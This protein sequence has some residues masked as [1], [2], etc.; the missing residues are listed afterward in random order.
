MQ[1]TRCFLRIAAA[2]WVSCGLL[3]VDLA[4]KVW[5]LACGTPT[6]TGVACTLQPLLLFT[7][8]G[9]SFWKHC[10]L[11]QGGAPEVWSLA[12]GTPTHTH[13]HIFFGSTVLFSR[14]GHQRCVMFQAPRHTRTSK[15]IFFGGAFF[16]PRVGLRNGGTA[17]EATGA[18][19]A[20][21]CQV[22]T[23]AC[24]TPHKHRCQF[25]SLEGCW[26]CD[27]TEHW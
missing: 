5:S 27:Q 7:H 26:L 11:F 13:R 2:G 19:P 3:T 6:H 25:C 18:H 8:L 17:R 24:V 12:C 15:R 9:A 10:F 4:P 20:C 23:Q 1:H 14:V 22:L 16:F 21:L